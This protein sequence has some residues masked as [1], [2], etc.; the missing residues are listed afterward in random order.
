[1]TADSELLPASGAVR[2]RVLAVDDSDDDLELL[3]DALH[4]T[5]LLADSAGQG[6]LASAG[7]PDGQVELHTATG[8]EAALESLREN[9]P[10]AVVISDMAMPG[11]DGV[12]LLQRVATLSP[13]T[14][15]VML[16]GQQDQAT[17]AEAVNEGRVFRFITKP[18]TA[19]RLAT[20]LQAAFEQHHLIV[21]EKELLGGTVRGAISVV[22]EILS[23]V[24]PLAFSRTSRVRRL[25]REIGTQLNADRVWELELAAMLSQVGLV[26]VPDATVRKVITGAPLTRTEISIYQAHSAIGA[27][28]VA[29]IPRLEAVAEMIRHQDASFDGA[30]RANGGPHGEA[31]PLGSRILKVAADYD[32]LINGGLDSTTALAELRRRA[33]R[34]DPLVLEAVFARRRPRGVGPSHTRVPLSELALG[35]VLAE[36]LLS[37]TGTTLIAKGQEVTPPLLSRAMNF[38]RGQLT[39]PSVTVLGGSDVGQRDTAV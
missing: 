8:G 34:Y 33:G 31:L 14:V 30:G 10:F 25:V 29:Q 22:S 38:L 28:L 7:P 37:V 1:M 5:G 27:D 16:T 11:M 39:E 17:A 18:A 2:L 9:G 15:R 32:Q 35:M 6:R 12:Q 3:T 13:D 24:S 20:T 21:A 36:D 4:A 19:S 23:M 26:A